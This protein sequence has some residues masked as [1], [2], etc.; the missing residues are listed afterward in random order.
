MQRNLTAQEKLDRGLPL[1]GDDIKALISSPG[2]NWI[3][4]LYVES[5]AIA[6][7]NA[8]AFAR[9]VE[10]SMHEQRLERAQARAEAI[11]QQIVGVRQ[12][13]INQNT[14]AGKPPM[15][16]NKPATLPLSVVDM[17]L[18]VERASLLKVDQT[19]MTAPQLAAY[20]AHVVANLRDQVA[21]NLGTV[22]KTA[23]GREQRVIELNNAAGESIKLVVPQLSAQPSATPMEKLFSINP[24]LAK[25]V[26]AD[27]EIQKAF[28]AAHILNK[29]SYLSAITQI[30]EI[31]EANNYEL[32]I[33]KRVKLAVAIGKTQSPVFQEKE[34]I[35]LRDA[36]FQNTTLQMNAYKTNIN[37]VNHTPSLATPLGTFARPKPVP[38]MGGNKVEDDKYKSPTPFNKK[39]GPRGQ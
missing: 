14:A 35:E 22:E 19:N 21:A 8:D 38:G 3:K 39:P 5:Q 17:T 32:D 15:E 1:S 16:A 31:G 9:Y 2:E 4:K 34:N 26:T 11:Q 7:I 33:S 24:E 13:I 20:Q 12:E 10:V 27:A 36:L 23:D 18:K 25:E 37:K 6:V 28:A 29:L 30:N